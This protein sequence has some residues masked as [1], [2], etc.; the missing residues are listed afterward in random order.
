MKTDISPRP[1]C[2]SKLLAV[3]LVAASVTSL[4]GCVPNLQTGFQGGI[5]VHAFQAVITLAG[6]ALIPIPAVPNRGRLLVRRSNLSQ[7]TQS[8]FQGLT[9]A[10]GF[11]DYPSAITDAQ[12]SVG[13]GPSAAPPCLENAFIEEVPLQGGEFFYFCHI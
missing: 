13:V 5:R 9:N 11:S 6:S 4:P 1:R 12:W 3:L 7:G 2:Y 8:V 10:A